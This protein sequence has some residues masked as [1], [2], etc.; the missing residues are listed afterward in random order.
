M[1]FF[2]VIFARIDINEIKIL[3]YRKLKLK[4]K[5]KYLNL[6]N[7]TENDRI[8]IEN[9]IEKEVEEAKFS[10]EKWQLS[11][12]EESRFHNIIDRI[13]G[14]TNKDGIFQTE[15][16]WYLRSKDNNNIKTYSFPIL[17][18]YVLSTFDKDYTLKLFKNG[19]EYGYGADSSTGKGIIKVES[20]EDFN[21]PKTGKTAIAL[22]P[23]ILNSSE[24]EQM[25]KN[26]E[27]Y[28]DVWTKYP[29]V[30]NS[31]KGMT[32]PFK[33]PI[34]FYKEGATIRFNDESK[35]KPLYIGNC[36]K[37]IHHIPD[38]MQYAIAPLFWI[39]LN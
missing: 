25:D 13:T 34:V 1:H 31:L 7:L 35:S 5:I 21:F 16:Y 39:N 33:K 14:T 28:A 29:K 19:I 17:D 8:D 26:F 2:E 36:A 27:L 6:N 38:I 18:I 24:Y 11:Y 15:Q 10:N 37:N 3:D 22:S 32:N 30:H 4:K 9:L 23:F 20:I 12:F